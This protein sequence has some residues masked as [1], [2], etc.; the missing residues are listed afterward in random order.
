MTALQPFFTS[1]L[2]RLRIFSRIDP[3]RDWIALIALACMAF[4]VGIV[5]NAWAFDTVANGGTIGTAPIEKA[6]IFDK[7]SLTTI[8]E[9]FATRAQEEAKY[10]SGVYRF[11]DPSQ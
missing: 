1:F 5:W 8:N 3:A 4:G 7:S 11:A 10:V 9:I 6:P 2:N